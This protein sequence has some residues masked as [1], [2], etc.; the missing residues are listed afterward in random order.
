MSVT[1]PES[2]TTA[3]RMALASG[4]TPLL[5]DVLVSMSSKP[6]HITINVAFAYTAPLDV[7][8]RAPLL[9]TDLGWLRAEAAAVRAQLAAFEEDWDA[10]GMSAYDAL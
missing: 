6:R 8:G 10:P 3:R 9:V 2:A 1:V 5:R 4:A 7:S